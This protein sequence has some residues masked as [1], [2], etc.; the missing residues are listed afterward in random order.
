MTGRDVTVL[1]LDGDPRPE[2]RR[3]GIPLRPFPGAFPLPAR[4]PGAVSTV[5]A[6]AALAGADVVTAMTG[7]LHRRALSRIGAAR[8]VSEWLDL[9]VRLARD[10]AERAE[11]ERDA[12]DP[13]TAGRRVSVAGLIGPLE[14]SAG[15]DAAPDAA[16][17][18]PEHRAHAGLLADA[19]VDL[20]RIEAIDTIAE[21]EAATV[22]ALETGLETWTGVLLDGTGRRLP[23]GEPLEAW[24][25]VVGA[26][27]PAALLLSAP[28]WEATAAALRAATSAL[29][30][31][32]PGIVPLLGAS[33]PLGTPGGAGGGTAAAP[34]ARAGA[35]TAPDERVPPASPASPASLLAAGASLLSAGRDGS[36]ARI[37]A[38]RAAADA[39]LRRHADAMAE[40]RERLVRW[41]A[42]AAE[43]AEHGAALLVAGVHADAPASAD[44][45]EP[46][47]NADLLPDGF[48]WDVV[49]ATRLREVP[50][51]RFRLAV[52]RAPTSGAGLAPA[53]LTAVVDALDAGAWLLVETA[54][55]TVL[56]A[57]DRL[58]DVQPASPG[59]GGTP[60]WLARRRP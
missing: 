25:S 23:S 24:L 39:E 10:A 13:H 21:S 58:S 5:L 17:A 53:T 18:G 15:P 3:R 49:D 9:A 4:E 41:I 33:F 27:G 52:V 40:R 59:P 8:R 32:H 6:G 31:L 34:D 48:A 47:A 29:P 14:G 54:S 22:A 1:V 60:A 37:S 16:T 30:S 42:Q 28:T 2:L 55:H 44:A 36:P 26:L 19:G 7:D 43:R 35:G 38:L 45:G 46:S 51:G 57:D 56:T 12:A 11:D 20:L 50:E